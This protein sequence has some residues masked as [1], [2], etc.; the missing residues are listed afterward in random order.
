MKIQPEPLRLSVSHGKFSQ[1]RK[2]KVQTGSKVTIAFGFGICKPE[3]KKICF[4][5]KCWSSH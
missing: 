3:D 5:Q 4:A 2:Y 1:T